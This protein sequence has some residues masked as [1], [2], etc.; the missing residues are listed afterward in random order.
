MNET[1]D[2]VNNADIVAFVHAKG[3]SNRVPSKNMRTMGD[4]PLFCH[5]IGSALRS[6]LVTRVVVDSDSDAILQ[7]GSDYGAV[8]L[9]RPPELATNLASGDDLAYW[10]ASNYPDSLIVLQVVPTAPFLKPESIDRAVQMLLSNPAVDSVAGV[11]SEALYQWKDGRPAYYRLDGTIPNS[12][13]MDK[14]I[15]ETTGLYVNRTAVVLTTK[16]RLNP[17]N[18]APCFLSKIESIDINTVE[19]FDFAELIWKGLNG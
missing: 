17:N 5:A 12:N 13:E 15:Y 9:K 2:C 7:I 6:S 8:P 4:R 16:R 14:V 3:T 10:Q 11:Y 19:D 18:C 1:K